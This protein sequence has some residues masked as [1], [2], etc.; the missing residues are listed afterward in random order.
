MN[1]SRLS[2]GLL[3]VLLASAPVLMAADHGDGPRATADPASDITDTFAWMSSDASR[4]NLVMDVFPSATASSKFSDSVQYVLHVGSK[5]AFTDAASTEHK[6]DVICTFDSTQK[7]SCWAGAS[8]YVKGDAS[9][10]SGLTSADG[11][12]KVFAGVR[13]DP[14]FFNLDGFKATATAVSAAASS[15]TFD[16]A[17]C[18]ALNSSTSTTLVTQLMTAPGGGAAVDHF[19]TKNV[20]SIVVS[21]D[22]SLVT[23]GGSLV[24]VWAATLK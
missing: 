18:P 16:P 22:K 14:F 21:L 17:G 9:N 2:A 19:V 8:T 1:R 3:A 13:N 24:S 11:K 4:V 7:I 12:L 23:Q 10:T 20:L 15:L 6:T 5:G